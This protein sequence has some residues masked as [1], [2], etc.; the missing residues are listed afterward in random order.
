MYIPTFTMLGFPASTWIGRRGQTS[1]L[2]LIGSVDKMNRCTTNFLDLCGFRNQV[3]KP[4]CNAGGLGTNVRPHDMR[5]AHA[6]WLLAGGA[7]LQVVK[8]RLGHGSIKTTERYL[9]TLPD[10]DESAID[11]FTAIRY[12]SSRT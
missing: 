10:Q 3:W 6:S 12:R 5:H 8:E 7:D 2:D 9:H 1:P 4:A 11:A